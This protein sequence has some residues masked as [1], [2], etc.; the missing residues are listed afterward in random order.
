MSTTARSTP[1]GGKN[2]KAEAASTPKTQ[3][4]ETNK[5]ESPKVANLDK[6]Q[7]VSITMV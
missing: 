2:N 3:K 4:T 7:V 6:S 5:S 1:R